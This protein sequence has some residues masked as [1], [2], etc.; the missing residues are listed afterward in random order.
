MYWHL[1]WNLFYFGH[2]FTMLSFL[3]FFFF[4]FNSHQLYYLKFLFPLL[5]S[6]ELFSWRGLGDTLIWA[7]PFADETCSGEAVHS[8]SDSVLDQAGLQ[9]PSL[10]LFTIDQGKQVVLM[11]L[12]FTSVDCYWPPRAHAENKGEGFCGL[13]RETSS[14]VGHR[15]KMKPGS[16][17]ATH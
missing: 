4:F 14:M 11:F 2:C 1:F 3:C 8:Q 15:L 9:I 16:M 12:G 5:E 6:W 17:W 13:T 7:F 10:T